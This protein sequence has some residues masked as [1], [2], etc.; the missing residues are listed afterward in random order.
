MKRVGD[1]IAL[2]LKVGRQWLT[3]AP[4][5]SGALL[6]GLS[7]IGAMIAI[8]YHGNKGIPPPS[9]PAVETNDV[10]AARNS[11]TPNELGASSAKNS[12]PK[13]RIGNAEVVEP[14]LVTSDPPSG[15]ESLTP[16]VTGLDKSLLVADPENE[17]AATRDKD[18]VKK[19]A[20]KSAKKTQRRAS[21]SDRDRK[22][23]PLREIRRAG[24]KITRVIRDIF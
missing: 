8:G 20:N 18:E 23:T 3:S 6:C 15:E 1:R 9:A 24:E 14:S 16:R 5:Y 10:V 13:S 21:S 12:L 4:R 7:V 19:T 17:K 11:T 22:F 2:F